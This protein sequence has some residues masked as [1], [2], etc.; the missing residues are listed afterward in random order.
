MKIHGYMGSCNVCGERMSG[1]RKRERLSQDQLAA[2]MQ[3]EGIQVNQKPS[4][5]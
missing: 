4:A 3:E 1:V 2:R 5:G